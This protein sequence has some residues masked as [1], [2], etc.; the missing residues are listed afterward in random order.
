M[1]IKF[2]SDLSRQEIYANADELANVMGMDRDKQ[3]KRVY[4]YPKEKKARVIVFKNPAL[5]TDAYRIAGLEPTKRDTIFKLFE[6]PIRITEYDEV[7][8]EFEQRK[9]PGVWGPN[10]DTLLFCRALKKMNFSDVKTIV[11]IG[12][13]SGFI[14]KYF[15]EKIKAPKLKEGIL[16]DFNTHAIRCSKDNINDSRVKF[17]VGNGVAYT[18]SKKFDLILCNPP[19]VP[20]PKSVDDNPYEG[21][22][23]LKYLKE[24][25]I[26]LLNPKGRIITNISSLCE[27]EINGIMKKSGVSARKLDSLVVPL[28]VLNILNNKKWMNYLLKHGLKK[29]RKNG[30]DYWQKITITEIKI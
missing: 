2:S 6:S 18:K 23:L 3:G 16:V 19:Y 12:S 13:G 1:I 24:N 29:Q 28:K 17:I 9:Y 21:T 11:E 5:V 20:R 27:K 26:G 10:I 25:V 22:G 30:Y 15:L 8:F 7:V 14:T 4:S